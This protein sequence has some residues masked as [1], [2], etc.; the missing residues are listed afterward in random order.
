MSN[1][2]HR[3]RVEGVTLS[4]TAAQAGAASDWRPGCCVAR[5]AAAGIR[6]WC[7]AVGA[8]GSGC[9][10]LPKHRPDIRRFFAIALAGPQPRRRREDNAR[11]VLSEA[12][13]PVKNPPSAQERAAA[14]EVQLALLAAVAERRSCIGSRTRTAGLGSLW[15][16][17]HPPQSPHL[18]P[19]RKYRSTVPAERRPLLVYTLA[20]LRQL[21]APQEADQ[22]Y[23][24][25][26]LDGI[27][28]KLRTESSSDSSLP[29]HEG[30]FRLEM[31]VLLSGTIGGDCE[32]QWR[33]VW[34]R[35]LGPCSEF[36]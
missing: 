16:L 17:E 30:L 24:R 15:Q 22:S 31:D 32:A 7:L 2:A 27:Y 1:G 14:H 35:D 12:R 4:S 9:K 26:D 6:S 34:K 28:Q 8:D 36:I 25:E 19:G 10:A 3:E 18:R 21:I 23:K 5:A 29:A 33:K 11:R 13:A 20:F